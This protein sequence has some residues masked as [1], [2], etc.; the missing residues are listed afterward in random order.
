M[1]N[2][3]FAL[4]FHCTQTIYCSLMQQFRLGACHAEYNVNECNYLQL[5]IIMLVIREGKQTCRWVS[6]IEI[7][8]GI[9]YVEAWMKF[10][11]IVTTLVYLFQI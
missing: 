10:V 2:Q 5:F 8:C 3:F 11:S 1:G 4:A 6:V 7:L 9:L